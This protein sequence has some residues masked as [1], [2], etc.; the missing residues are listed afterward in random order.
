MNYLNEQ[1][2]GVITLDG[3]LRAL[4][5]LS[6]WRR[7]SAVYWVRPPFPCLAMIFKV[8]DVAG[9]TFVATLSMQYHATRGMW[10]VYIP[11]TY[12]HDKGEMIYKVVCWDGEKARH[13]CGEGILRVY[14]GLVADA[15]DEPMEADGCFAFFPDGKWRRVSVFVDEVGE[16]AFSVAQNGYA[17]IEF[18]APPTTP[19]AYN[20]VT[21]LYYAVSG[22]VDEAGEAYLSVASEGVEG[23]NSAFAKN[24]TTGFFYRVEAGVDEVGEAILSVGKEEEQK[25][26]N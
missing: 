6:A 17:T 26:A 20:P 4:P 5:M 25:N 1:N 21:G 18:G 7:S 3:T 14:G 9:E 13:V 11:G 12:L 22:F 16:M 10:R 19:Y 15:A 8:A 2:N 23:Q 24:D